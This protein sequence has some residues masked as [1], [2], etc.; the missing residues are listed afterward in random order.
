[1]EAKEGIEGL[2]EAGR[3]EILS[4]VEFDLNAGCWLWARAY[5]GNGYGQ[6]GRRG[7]HR[8]SWEAFNGPIPDGLWVLHKCDTPACVNP[9]HLRLGSQKDNM[10]E[11]GSKGRI[12]Q[13]H[14]SWDRRTHCLHGHL[15]TPGNTYVRANGKRQCVACR[16][17][18]HRKYREAAQ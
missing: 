6:L 5:T 2:P 14:R 13:G 11:C 3:A 12:N 17:T 8:A 15:I 16:K 7:A 4:A 18:I 9:H 1:M 10:S